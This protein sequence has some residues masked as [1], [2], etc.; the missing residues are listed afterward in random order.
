ML[1]TATRWLLVGILSARVAPTSSAQSP[2]ST[3]TYAPAVMASD[4]ERFHSALRDA[5]GGLADSASRAALDR[6]YASL[7]EEVRQPRQPVEFYR[8][9]LRLTASV[10]DGHTRAFANGALREEMGRQGL[11]PFHVTIQHDRIFVLRNL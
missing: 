8:M 6:T 5:H 11:L 10:H 4:L 1:R 9:V 3:T 7:V 2:T